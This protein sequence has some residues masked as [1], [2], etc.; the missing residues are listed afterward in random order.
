M[1]RGWIALALPVVW[2]AG[3][4]AP[5]GVWR[6]T[7]LNAPAAGRRWGSVVPRIPLRAAD[8]EATTL[9]AVVGPLCIVGFVDAAEPDAWTP[10]AGLAG[11]A[12]RMALDH[13]SVVQIAVPPDGDLPAGAVGVEDEPPGNLLLLADPGRVAWEAF[14]RPEPGTLMVVDDDRMIRRTGRLED[15]LLVVIKARS[16]ARELEREQTEW[17]REGLDRD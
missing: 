16:L 11:L 1:K 5:G 13:V 3:C 10:R 17:W 7:V 8:G 9:E 2:A 14:G 6:G 4:G 12:R 15:P